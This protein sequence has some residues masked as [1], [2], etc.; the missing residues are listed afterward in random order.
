MENA[1]SFGMLL[2]HSGQNLWRHRLYGVEMLMQ[3]CS[4]LYICNNTK[5]WTHLSSHF[6]LTG[7]S[8]CLTGVAD[9]AL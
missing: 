8:K 1:C 5:V 6:D 3:M 4:N 9:A 2:A 7:V